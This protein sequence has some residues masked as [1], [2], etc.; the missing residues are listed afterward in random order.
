MS[1]QPGP[2]MDMAGGVPI[3]PKVKGW[4]A[5]IILYNQ[6]LDFILNLVSLKRPSPRKM[7]TNGQ[8]DGRSETHKRVN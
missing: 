5:I 2:A 4:G 1:T 7:L 3:L 8:T 6:P